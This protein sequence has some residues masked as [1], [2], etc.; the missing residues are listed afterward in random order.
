MPAIFQVFFNGNRLC[1]EPACRFQT[2]FKPNL[3]SGR[4]RLASS[5]DVEIQTSR[6]FSDLVFILFLSGLM[7]CFFARKMHSTSEFA[8]IVLSKC[9]LGCCCQSGALWSCLGL[10]SFSLPVPRWPLLVAAA[11]PPCLVLGPTS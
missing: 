7:E 9:V 3:M 5:K 2:I 6:F 11:G 8:K 1:Q 4:G 10:R